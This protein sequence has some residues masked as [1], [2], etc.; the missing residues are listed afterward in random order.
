MAT[1]HDKQNKRDVMARVRINPN[2]RPLEA[3][4]LKAIKEA[5]FTAWVIEHIQAEMQVAERRDERCAG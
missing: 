5:G 2:S 3:E 4:R 1:W